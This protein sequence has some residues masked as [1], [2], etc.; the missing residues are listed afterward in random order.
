MTPLEIAQANA[1]LL[2][3]RKALGVGPKPIDKP[4]QAIADRSGM[5]LEDYFTNLGNEPADTAQPI[6]TSRAAWDAF[7]SDRSKVLQ[8]AVKTVARWYQERIKVGG[9]L[10]LAGN[11]GC[12]KT[13]LARAIYDLYGFGAAYL[14][15][16]DVIGQIQA[17]YGSGG[18]RSLE[19]VVNQCRRAKLLIYDDLGAYETDNLKWMQNI[20]MSLFNGRKEAGQAT[21]ITT[22]L[23]LTQTIIEAGHDTI[24]SPLQNRLGIRVYSRLMGAVEQLCYYVNLFDVPDYRLR[25]F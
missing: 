2:A 1:A 7:E 3:K 21:F 24:Y 18:G 20:Y 8:R 12:G 5:T 4:L 6:D 23:Q 22:N 10:I 17:G 15:E 16:V 13:H 19:S 9:A 14:N 11:C 25:N